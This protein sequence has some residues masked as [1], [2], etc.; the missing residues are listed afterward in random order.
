MANIPPPKNQLA[1]IP[2]GD[3]LKFQTKQDYLIVFHP[4]RG[5]KRIQGIPDSQ[6]GSLICCFNLS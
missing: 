5:R 4:K 1:L 3:Q 2:E 6:P